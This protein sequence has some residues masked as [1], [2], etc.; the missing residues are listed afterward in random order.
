ML[1]GKNINLRTVRE[2]DFDAI[3]KYLNDVRA[4][5]AYE[6][7]GF[8][9][10]APMRKDFAATGFWEADEGLLNITD[11]QDRLLGYISFTK[12]FTS[13]TRL[14]YEISYAIGE[15]DFW[16]QGLMTEAV[17]L[18]VPFLFA[19]K[20]IERIQ[21]VVHPENIG[22]RRVLEKCGFQ[23]EG[24]LRKVYFFRGNLIDLQLYSILREEC[25][26]LCLEEA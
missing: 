16:G 25:P 20:R 13:S 23:L 24:V 14:A 11:K 7:I 2:S 10:E 8:H 15:P 4:R 17:S 6:N 22:S 26:P 9:P 18:F 12:P 19:T 21:A 3:F 1:Y 5:G